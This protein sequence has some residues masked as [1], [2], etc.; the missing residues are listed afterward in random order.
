MLFGFYDKRYYVLFVQAIF[1]GK[2]ALENNPFYAKKKKKNLRD[3]VNFMKLI[4]L[5][6]VHLNQNK[7]NEIY[8]CIYV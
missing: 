8:K 7:N 5:N 1:F 4:F 2:T 6:W 3:K